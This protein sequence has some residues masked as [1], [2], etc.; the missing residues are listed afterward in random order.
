MMLDFD[1]DDM[2]CDLFKVLLGTIKY[3]LSLRQTYLD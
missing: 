1:N 2:V 3:A